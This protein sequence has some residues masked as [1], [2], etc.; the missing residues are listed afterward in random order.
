MR[1]R[2]V[3]PAIL[4]ALSCVFLACSQVRGEP[5][6]GVRFAVFTFSF[7]GAACIWLSRSLWLLLGATR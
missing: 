3:F 2:D 4:W 7:G 1:P 5:G 6:G